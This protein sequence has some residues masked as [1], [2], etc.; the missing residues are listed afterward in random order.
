MR[1]PELHVLML[2]DRFE[3]RGSSRQTISLARRLPEFGIRPEIV[4]IDAT[5]LPRAQRE[6]LVLRELRHLKSPLVGWAARH[7]LA[8]ELEEHPPDVIHV[9]QRSMLAVGRS[10]AHGL[11]RPYV[12]S[13]HDYLA[14]R[15]TLRMDWTWCRRIIAVSDA[16]TGDVYSDWGSTS[17]TAVRPSR[18]MVFAA[19]AR[20]LEARRAIDRG[21]VVF[22]TS[23][24]R[25][26]PRSRRTGAGP[27]RS[28]SCSPSRTRSSWRNASGVCGSGPATR[29]ETTWRKGG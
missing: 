29:I 17:T 16:S 24:A 3:V 2:A 10:L 8:R 15:E 25:C 22:A 23:C 7:W 19:E 13:I 9:Q 11:E 27:R 18:R 20:R 28:P 21:C 4:C 6:G 1:D 14:P 12:V 26:R 5:V